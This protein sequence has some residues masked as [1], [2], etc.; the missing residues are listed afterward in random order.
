M[1]EDGHQE[2]EHLATTTYKLKMINTTMAMATNENDD[3]DDIK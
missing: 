1:Y 3:D 2:M